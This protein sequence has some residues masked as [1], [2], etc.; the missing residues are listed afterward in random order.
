MLTP[1][2]PFSSQ[3]L[4]LM[5]GYTD[6]IAP[7]PVVREVSEDGVLHKVITGEYPIGNRWRSSELVPGHPLP[8]PQALFKRLDDV[9]DEEEMLASS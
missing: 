2:L 3:R 8:Q 4:H 6:V 1:F 9:P 7:Q 5:L